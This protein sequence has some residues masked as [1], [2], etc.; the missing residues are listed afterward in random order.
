MGWTP[1]YLKDFDLTRK[2]KQQLKA[3]I[4]ISDYNE[5]KD[6]MFISE[7]D[8]EDFA[9]DEAIEFEIISKNHTQFFDIEFWAS[10]LQNDY[11]EIEIQ[12]QTYYYR[13]L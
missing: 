1:Y 2:E 7:E 4:V 3:D 12:G 9:L 11:N 13:D 6:I 5:I 10:E 8:W